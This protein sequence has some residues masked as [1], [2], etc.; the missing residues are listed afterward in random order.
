M[1]HE[2]GNRD[3]P[4]LATIEIPPLTRTGEYELKDG[5]RSLGRFAVNFFDAGESDLTRLSGGAVAPA[6]TEEA[7]FII[8]ETSP[9]TWMMLIC[10]TLAFAIWNWSG[11]RGSRRKVAAG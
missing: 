6:E 8:T 4:R 11:L 7:A 1:I 10:L 5:D 9:W 2:A 3:L